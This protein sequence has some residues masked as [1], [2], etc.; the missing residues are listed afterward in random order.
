MISNQPNISK[1][2]APKFEAATSE[3][4]AIEALVSAL[5]SDNAQGFIDV[6]AAIAAY[7]QTQA[8]ADKADLVAEVQ[9]VMAQLQSMTT[10][11]GSF[12]TNVS[13]I[14]Q[15]TSDTSQALN[16]DIAAE[17]KRTS[18]G[19]LYA[20]LSAVINAARD[21]GH[22]SVVNA[23]EGVKN[24]V[25]SVGNWLNGNVADYHA[26]TLASVIAEIKRTSAG[27][28]Y[29]LLSAVI[30]AARDNVK[31]E[32]NSV[33]NWLDGNVAG[34]HANTLASVIAEIKRTSAGSLYELIASVVQ[35]EASTIKN[36]V[37]QAAS[38]TSVNNLQASVNGLTNRSIEGVQSGYVEASTSGTSGEDKCRI[39]IP[40]AAVDVNKVMISFDGGASELNADISQSYGAGG[41]AWI[42]TARMTNSTTLRIAA[43]RG[44]VIAGRWTI[45]EFN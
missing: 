13:A 39:D 12:D 22:T 8:P 34:Y 27:S 17:I 16:D 32:V 35:S 37:A 1:I 10:V 19:S 24:E 42:C 14:N 30:N 3:R 31:S 21:S 18:A 9:A 33:G 45:T 29:A 11:G 6:L 38:Q 28:L 43:R 36:N 15:H 20:L 2:L 40:V 7:T 23:S 5:K 26:N 41:N 25:N 44:I 4:S